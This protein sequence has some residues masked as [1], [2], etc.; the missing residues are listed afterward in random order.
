MNNLLTKWN[1]VLKEMENLVTAVS[2]DLYIETLEPVKVDNNKL[3]I[4]AST[5]SNKNQLLRL[6]KE[7]LLNVVKNH[8]DNVEDL[9]I[10]EP[11]EK[12]AFLEDVNK[13]EDFIET[14]AM[15]NEQNKLNEKYTFDNFVVGKSNQ[16]VYSACENVAKNPGI[17]FNPLYIYGGVGLGK[18]HL[19]NAIG[20]YIRKNNKELKL[21]Y[22]TCEQFMNDFTRSIREKTIEA[23]RKKYRDVDVLMV[24]DIQFIA[25]K[26]GTQEEFFNTFNDLYQNNKQ[27]ILASDKHPK[28]METLEDRLKSR[29]SGGL[30]QDIQKPDFETRLAILQKKVELKNYSIDNDV[31]L[32]L[33][34]KIDSNIRELEG[35]LNRVVSLSMLINKPRATM[36]DAQEALKDIEITQSQNITIDKIMTVICRYYNIKKEE[37]IGKK[38]N[39]EVVDPRQICIYIITE[40]LDVPLITIGE[41]FGGRDHTTIIHARDKIAENIKTNKSLKTNVDDLIAMIKAENS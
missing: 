25:N 9:I 37:L 17:N 2:Y 8:F 30:T 38:K 39:K 31:L 10:I 23:F 13:V 34:E 7:K 14:N 22:V 41:A 6:H 35:G 1:E 24:D 20:N 32:Y 40:L 21:L 26:T 27:I 15:F 19:L 28:N 3:I 18:T 16:V 4:L 12:D 33:A 11:S 36:E 5:L 29:F